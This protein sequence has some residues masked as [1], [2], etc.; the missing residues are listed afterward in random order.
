MKKI[1]IFALAICLVLVMSVSAFAYDYGGYELPKQYLMAGDVYNLEDGLQY[2]GKMALY[3]APSET[4]FR[5]YLTDGEFYVSDNVVYSTSDTIAFSFAQGDQYWIDNMDYDAVANEPLFASMNLYWATAD[6]Y[7]TDG[8]LLL[9][10][11]ENFI[12]PPLAEQ[13]QGV[14]TEELHQNL[15]PKMAGDLKILVVCGITLIALLTIF[16][17]FWRGFAIFLS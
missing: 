12:L 11:D 16:T 6:I 17:I 3:V 9:K 10:G 1:I 13:I 2:G 5:L 4:L 7:N 8:E 15:I 14:T